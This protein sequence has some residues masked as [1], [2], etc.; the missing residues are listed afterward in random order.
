M[1]TPG[2]APTARER[3]ALFDVARLR[4]LA[5][6]Q[7]PSDD[8]CGHALTV[9]QHLI[10]RRS[11]GTLAALSET[12][13]EQSFNER[14]FAEV[15]GYRTLFRDGQAQYHLRPKGRNPTNRRFDD[16]SLGFYG[17]DGGDPIAVAE[18]KD[19][20][21]DLDAPQSG[22]SYQGASAVEQAHRQASGLATVKWVIV[23]NFDQIR[24]YRNGDLARCETVWLSE[25]LS[26]T[27]FRRA[28]SLL[29]KT[30]L[31]GSEN[32]VSPLER[33][34][35]GGCP[36]IVPPVEGRVR[37]VQT[38]LPEAQLGEP[39]ALPAMH[40]ALDNALGGL[41]SWGKLQW[42][43]IHPSDSIELDEDRLV[44]TFG[45][46]RARVEFTTSGVLHIS[47][48]ITEN[49]ANF[50]ASEIA[51]RHAMFLIL[52]STTTALLVGNSHIRVACDLLEVDGGS[53]ISPED[54]PALQ[55]RPGIKSTHAPARRRSLQGNWVEGLV[56]QVSSA[57]TELL[58][59]FQASEGG[60]T[61][62]L[63]YSGAR[64]KKD[65]DTVR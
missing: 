38:A 15:F 20:D 6:E 49:N 44:A 46:G 62:R 63:K 58:F 29:S 36:M 48:Y 64:M 7:A 51:Q 56:G 14:L 35:G 19:P 65:V 33:L 2:S 18:L 42:L 50:S 25:I 21:A 53:C 54:G 28:H 47:E 27:A 40:D 37:L 3:Q 24:V 39:L 13:V 8:E 41:P 34:Y 60:R 59:P 57:V 9:L 31:L 4:L 16:F 10:A 43:R 22:P 12:R 26:I 17:P 52:A 32:K 45:M 11:D 5:L 23:S 55:V 1:T 30:T 61:V